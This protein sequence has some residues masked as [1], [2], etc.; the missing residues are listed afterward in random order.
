VSLLQLDA[1][2]GYEYWFG[3]DNFRTITKYNNSTYYGM[4]VH[5]LAQALRARRGGRS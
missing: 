3:F 1:A 4:T 2:G 5:Q